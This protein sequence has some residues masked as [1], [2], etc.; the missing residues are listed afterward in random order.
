MK[1]TMSLP[2][3][4]EVNGS[5]Q[6]ETASSCHQALQTGRCEGNHGRGVLVKS[7][8]AARREHM[9][10]MDVISADT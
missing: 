8:A 6:Q 2:E 3:H 10:G 9:L 7:C 1:A 5:V 4:A